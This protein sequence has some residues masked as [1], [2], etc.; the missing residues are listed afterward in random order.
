MKLY[1]IPNCDTIKKAR[2]WLDE[3]AIAYEF[4]DYKKQGID[5]T[6]LKR[7]CREF[8]HEQ[9]VNQ[10]GTT[11]RKLDERAR[12]NLTETKAIELMQQQPSVIKRP[13][14]DTGERL[15]LGFDAENY[16]TLRRPR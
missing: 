7:W 9:L 3:H 5:A 1:G 8:G 11:W 10:R 15:L 16:Q 4:H 2:A 6:T 14:L 12:S 13:I